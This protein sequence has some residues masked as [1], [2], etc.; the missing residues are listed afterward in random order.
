MSANRD[1][2][3]IEQE[4]KSSAPV[5]VT[6]LIIAVVIL[7]AI[8]FTGTMVVLFHIKAER[9][10]KENSSL[11]AQSSERIVPENHRN[12]VEGI[13]GES[14]SDDSEEH[15][16]S[17]FELAFENVQEPFYDAGTLGMVEDIFSEADFLDL[18][19]SD[20]EVT[21]EGNLI[22][23]DT[24]YKELSDDL[25]KKTGIGLSKGYS[26]RANKELEFYA[27]HPGYYEYKIGLDYHNFN[28][29]DECLATIDISGMGTVRGLKRGD[30]IER[31][32][33][34]YGRPQRIGLYTDKT[35]WILYGG[36][37]GALRIVTDKTAQRVE[38]IFIELPN[39]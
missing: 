3:K 4:Q 5:F 39:I 13:S 10:A 31:V 2:N 37:G 29:A 7:A 15:E 32:A 12:L 11:V 20:L 27:Y 34:L 35:V 28:A 25:E 6:P 26:S 17:E 21:Y 23:R 14:E 38:D 1:N 36:A 8:G 33:G 24:P 30:A 18:N 19:Q 16:P 22:N 9:E